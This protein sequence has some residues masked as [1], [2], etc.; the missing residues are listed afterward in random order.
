M[1]RSGVLL[2]LLVLA[3]AGCGG[4][5]STRTVTVTQTVS[6]AAETTP[7]VQPEA[8][9]SEFCDSAKGDAVNQASAEAQGA[10]ND[11]DVAAF[12]RAIAKFLR[13]GKS[14]PEGAD[15][16]AQALDFII[17]LAN[18]GSNGNL[19]GLDVTA[20]VKRLRAFQRD[21]GL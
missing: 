15:C 16:A 20:T 8:S 11:A 9:P 18:D 5:G 6:V 10:Y 21:H 1:R 19:E 14:A 7:E 3:F 4:D 2:V 12:K 17:Q 13:S